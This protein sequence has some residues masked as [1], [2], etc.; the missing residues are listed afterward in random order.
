MA[1]LGTA[2]CINGFKNSEGDAIMKKCV[3]HSDSPE[4]R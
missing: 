4:I 2:E 3:S 1:V